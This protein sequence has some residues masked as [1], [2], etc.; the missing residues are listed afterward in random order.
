MYRTAEGLIQ[1]YLQAGMQIS[2][3][4]AVGEKKNANQKKKRMNK[5]NLSRPCRNIEG[6]N[7]N[8]LLKR[9]VLIHSR[10]KGCFLFE[11][12]N[13]WSLLNGM[14]CY[15]M[16]YILLLSSEDKPSR[17]THFS[18]FLSCHLEINHRGSLD[19]WTFFLNFC[20]N[21][22]YGSCI[23]APLNLSC[24]KDGGLFILHL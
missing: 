14:V 11:L 9:C 12:S 17:C 20:E 2:R 10:W 16:L 5:V 19:P 4:D 18:T 13:S 23:F 8:L 6:K 7:E 21:L 24:R 1:L 15:Q 3:L 22:K